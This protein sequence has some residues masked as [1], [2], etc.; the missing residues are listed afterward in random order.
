MN[1]I[2]MFLSYIQYE[3]RGS[4][5]T[6][7][8][9]KTDLEQ[10][11]SFLFSQNCSIEQATYRDIRNWLIA[12][13]EENNTT[14]TVNRKISTLKAFYRFLTRNK[15]VKINP[16]DK[17]IAPKQSKKLT[18]FVSE[19]AMENLFEQL[20]F[21]DD[22]E[23]ARDRMILELFYATGIRLSELAQIKKGDLDLDSSTIR[24]FG[25]RKRERIIPITSQ[26]VMLLCD[27]IKNLE[28][29]FGFVNYNENIFVTNKGKP[30]YQKLIYRIVRKYLDAVTTVDK[31]SPHVIRHTFAT[32]LLDNGADL[33]AIKELLGHTSLAAT[34]IY[35]HTSVEKI[36]KM[37]KQAH[38]RA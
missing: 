13:M 6:L 14:R 34:Q 17:V 37:Y 24:I 23:G 25:K 4:P 8:A 36:K 11:V 5:H 19:Q 3:R 32:H 27:Y 33:L 12:L 18:P 31:R 29:E 9:Y 26:I 20:E 28:K 16:M 22:F 2:D 1:S 21:T 35:T 7:I 10:Y 30:I 38:P 15:Y